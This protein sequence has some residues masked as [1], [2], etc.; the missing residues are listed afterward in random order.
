M[1]FNRA[2]A[3]ALLGILLVGCPIRTEHKVETT[4]KIEAHIVIDVRKVQEQAGQIESEVRAESEAPKAEPDPGAKAGAML[5]RPEASYRLAA[6][7]RSFWSIFDISSTSHAAD[8]DENAAIARRKER[9]SSIKQALNNGCF[10]ENNTGY[11]EL[12]PCDQLEGADEKARL[13]VLAED[14]NRDRRIIYTALSRRQ[15]LEPDQV[16]AIGA[17]YAGEIRKLLSSGQA[18]QTPTDDQLYEEFLNSDLG[19]KLDRPKP[20][21]WVRV[22]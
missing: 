19:R 3:L 9:A 21:V 11:V 7:Q 20:G 14:E 13:Q 1:K 5:A 10:G 4:H 2:G 8:V 16:D 12:H 17:I 15:G 22:P 6:P 18:F